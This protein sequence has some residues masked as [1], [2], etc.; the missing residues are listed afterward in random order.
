MDGAFA[1][2]EAWVKLQLGELDCALD[3]RLRQVVAGRRSARCC[4]ASSTRTHVAP[5]WP[6]SISLAALQARAGLEA[7]PSPRSD[8]R[9]RRPQ[10]PQ[11]PRQPQRPAGVGPL[12]RRAPRR[13]ADRR[14]AAPE[15][16]PADHRR[17]RGRDHRRRRL[18]PRAC[19]R[20]AWIRGIDHRIDPMALGVRDLAD[21]SV[22]HAWRPRR[23]ASAPAAFDIAELHAPFTHQELILRE[24]LGL[25]D[26]VDDQPV[27]RRAGR[28]PDHGRR[29]RPLRRGGPADH[30]R[31][32]RPGRRPRHQRAVPAAEPGVRPRGRS[33]GRCEARAGRSGAMRVEPERVADR[34]HRPDQARSRPWRRLDRRPGARGR[35]AGRWPTPR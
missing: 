19:E 27:G 34:R 11:R 33:D 9:G 25:G 28:Q 12:G 30:R 31:R 7:G 21:V 1:L 32:G 5:L 26:D 18:R 17:R 16:L 15:R 24:A 14:P 13:G 4:P 29:P 10:P 2:Y 8:G 6:D 20:P 35:R 3:L 22:G 23:R